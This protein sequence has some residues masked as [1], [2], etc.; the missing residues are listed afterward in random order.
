MADST[1]DVARQGKKPS[2]HK[3]TGENPILTQP[4][5]HPQGYNIASSELTISR[6]EFQR[7]FGDQQTGHAE[8]V[9][10]PVSTSPPAQL[11]H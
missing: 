8:Y 7:K 10:S 9:E 1:G 3:T 2:Q 6:D 5:L 11:D 4:S